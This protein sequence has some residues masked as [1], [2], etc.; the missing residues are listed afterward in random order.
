MIKKFS[1]T[2]TLFTLLMT[3]LLTLTLVACGDADQDL[4]DEA[5]DTVS[6]V[7]ATG[8]NVNSVTQ[9]LNLPTTLAGDITITWASDN[10]AV[11]AN[12]GTVTRGFDD[13]TVTLTATLTLGD[14]TATKDFEVTVKGYDVDA[15]LEAINITGALTYN[16]TTQIYTVNGNITLPATVNGLDIEWVSTQPAVIS[17][18]G[19]V[20]RPAYLQPN[21]NVILIATINDVE[22]EFSMV[23]PAITE[24]PAALILSEARDALLLSGIGDGVSQDLNL[25]TTVGTEGV[26]VTWSS[27]NTAVISNLGVVVRGDDNVT[28][29]LTATLS[30][31]TES[32]TKEFEVV[33]LAAANFVAVADIEEAIEISRSGENNLSYTR[34][35]VRIQ[36][37][38][39]LGITNDGVVFADASGILFAYMGQRIDTVVVGGVYDVRGLTDRYFGSWQL[40]NTA[41]SA[42]PVIWTESDAPVTVVTPIEATPTEVLEDHIIPTPEAPD[43]N[44]TYYRLTAKVR[45]QGTGNYDTVFVDADYAGGDI[46]TAANSAHASEGIMIYYQSNKAAF[47][48]FDGQVVTFNALFYGYRSDRTVFTILFIE[49]VED[50]ETSLDDQGLVDAAETIIKNG[51]SAE[52]TENT[53]LTLPTSVLGTTIAWASNDNALIN[54]T[55]GELT[56]PAEGQ[57]EVTLTATITKGEVTKVVEIK[58][59]VGALE[60]LS[61]ADALAKP[62]GSKVWIE[63]TVSYF[64]YSATFSNAAVFLQ[65]GTAG[66]FLFRLAGDGVADIKIGDK[67]RVVGNRTAFNG[68]E[69]LASPWADFEIVSSGNALI[70]EE[71]VE[72][73]D[74]MNFQSQYVYL[75]GTLK[76]PVTISTTGSSN[77]TILVVGAKEVTIS[78]PHPGD[79]ADPAV[80]AAL[81]ALLE[82]MQAGDTFSVFGPLGWN[83]GP[84]MMVYTA[85]DI[86]VGGYV[87]LNDAEKAEQVATLL[88]IDDEI[89]EAVTLTL[90]ATGAHGSTIAWTSSDNAVIDPATGIVTLP[91]TGNVSVTL[92]ATVTVG[93]EEFVRNIVITVGEIIRTVAYA[94]DAP[95]DTVMTVQGQITAVQ[96]NATDDKAVLFMEDAEEG[97]YVYKVP[98]EFK[99]DLVVGNV[100]KVFGA[101]KVFNDLAQIGS[102][103]GIE[104]VSTV[105]PAATPT[106]VTDP[107]ELINVQG[108]LISVTGYLRQDYVGTP[109][110]FHLV[111]TAG[112]FALRVVSGSDAPAADIDAIRLKLVDA[113]VGSQVTVVA[114]AGR[115]RANMQVMLFNADQITVGAVGAEADLGAVAAALFVEPADNAEV[116]ADLTLPDAGLF[117]SVVTW[118]SS[119]PAVITN[120]GVVTRPV[121]EDGDA[122]VVMTYSLKIGANEYKTGTVEYVVLKADPIITTYDLPEYRAFANTWEGGA[123]TIHGEEGMLVY[124]ATGINAHSSWTMQVIQDATALNGAADNTGH[125]AMVAGKTYRVTFDA[126]ASIAG[127]IKLAIGHSTAWVPY[128]E[129]A[130]TAI[131]TEMATYTFTFTLDDIAKD[132]S[133][134]AQ[135]KIEL[136]NLFNGQTAPQTFYLDNVLIEVMEGEVYVDAMLIENG[137]MDEAVV[138]EPVLVTA[139]YLAGSGTTNMVAGNNAV[140]LGLDAAIFNVVSTERVNSPLHV[141]LNNAGQIRLYGSSDTNGNILTISIDAAYTITGVKFVFGSTVGNALILTGATEQFN[142]ALTASSTV[143][144]TG[145]DV[146]VFSI[147]NTNS[148]TGQIYIL[149]IEI[150]YVAK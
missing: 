73:D 120:A 134:P 65:D 129:S 122:T 105:T 15:A 60:L 33:V 61:I 74:F 150:T 72:A 92:T 77:V 49:T 56:L 128:F 27:S 48:A 52:Y 140:S 123:A 80:R 57:V 7:F 81:V 117:G 31:G 10:T 99:A 137:T 26:T 106:V 90:P 104:V 37:V 18:A 66:I 114:G 102:V 110:D 12:N 135:F 59:A 3:L 16:A 111:T 103:T 30:L 76:A 85:A 143:E 130:M 109:S 93:T 71:V 121:F 75:T 40:N 127:D 68:L 4:V 100:I 25:P 108:Q 89:E 82:G 46:P 21:A 125:M 83:N 149:S 98:A 146:S 11:I 113:L 53:T 107:A 112:T 136:G 124:T 24:K 47:D 6:I 34:T 17:N 63:G 19:V 23:V 29:T 22:R 138:A 20:T 142:G 141:G 35:Y 1:F 32:V 101:R 38:T 96:F 126:K 43:I 118:V 42:T 36:G 79:Y 69:Q 55:T 94:N 54:P 70:A 119:D 78:V 8:D 39:I 44:Y 28:V 67:I 145:L 87:E 139:A 91:A 9:N 84:R 51:I 116:V 50:I 133:V 144:Y 5:L 2:K 64:V 147:K 14:A 41:D 62:S 13:V 86:V 88:D 45:I 58:V 148:S 132:Y 131:T 95:I 115:F 97:I